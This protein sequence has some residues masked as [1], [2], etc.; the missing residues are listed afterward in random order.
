MNSFNV[1]LTTTGRSTLNRMLD[2]IT[3]QLNKEDYLT[4]IF[5]TR[6]AE[7]NLKTNA[8]TIIIENSET[9]GSWG[10]GSR[11]KWQSHLPGD[12]M[13]NA[14]DDDIYVFD[15]MKTVR[16]H[17]IEDKLYVFQMLMPGAGELPRNN[18]LAL[19]NIG[20]PCGVYK[21]RDLPEW[22]PIHGGDFFFY[23]ALSKNR[24]VEFVNK[25]IYKVRDA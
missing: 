5:D 6:P 19:G 13:M 9:L 10:H 16:D 15:A 22:P 11:T 18:T 3:P 25:V 17:C 14:D 23:E 24:P 7:L 4:I 21:N 2:S 8:T 1:V 20:T 12:F